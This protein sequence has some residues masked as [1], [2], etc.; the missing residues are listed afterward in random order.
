MKKIVI[1]L[2]HPAHFYIYKNV[3]PQL[4]RDGHE[5]EIL[6][7]KKDVLESLLQNA[8][9]PYHNILKEGR[10]NTKL[11]MGWA[12][13]KRTWRIG[14]FCHNFKPDIL[15]GT[16]VENS[17]IGK[18]FGIPVINVNEDDAEVVPLYAKM[19]YPW[20]TE[21]LNP[22]VC[23][24]GKWD[25]KALKYDS[26]HELAYLHPNHFT[27]DKKIVEK[28]FQTNTP[29]YVIRFAKLNAHHDFGI[30][31]INTDIA[32]KIIDILEQHG[33]VF[34]TSERELE[35]DF[36]KYR[37][38]I[39]PLDI[40]HIMAFAT[41]YIGDS[42][43]MAA[44]SGV[45]GVPFIRFNDFVGRIG[46]L[47]ELEDKYKLGYGIKTNDEK[48]LYEVISELVNMPDLNE[49]F[50]LRRKQM[51]IDKIDFAKYLIWFIENYPESKRIIKENPSIQYNFK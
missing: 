12:L 50:K 31:G 7:K 13:L 43:T 44:E 39:N 6:I 10:K 25:N 47:A 28:Y 14:R 3:I 2:G 4:K 5:I 37:I 49:I 40:H 36:E 34:I 26:Y 23:N 42:Q 35:N 22:I 51:L 24:S 15:T 21:I 19:G 46:Y 30:K 27:P 32:R 1:T 20:A 41:L 16:S 38:H 17:F 29:Y 9:I 48:Q 8:G 11:A 45:L 33:R 18:L